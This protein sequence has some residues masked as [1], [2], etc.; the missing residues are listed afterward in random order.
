M[1]AN[2]QQAL[3]ADFQLI[4]PALQRVAQAMEQ[5]GFLQPIFV[6]SD[7]EAAL[8][9]GA[10]LVDKGEWG[11]QYACQVTFL[12]ALQEQGLI[13]DL[14][15]FE[16]GYRPAATHATIILFSQGET[17]GVTI[18]YPIAAE[19]LVEPAPSTDGLSEEDNIA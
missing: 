12:A 16:R 6:L 19:Q 4:G 14:A 5:A 15:A 9:L 18:P 8:Q 7:T 11:N 10:P 17:Y 2:L 1:D 3:A 13:K